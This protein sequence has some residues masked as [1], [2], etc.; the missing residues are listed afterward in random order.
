[1]EVMMKV[2]NNSNG[3]GSRVKYEEE[4]LI[5]R[6]GA[7]NY[8]TSINNAITMHQSPQ[9]LSTHHT[10]N[11]RVQSPMQSVKMLTA[12][13]DQFGASLIP[14]PKSP[15]LAIMHSKSKSP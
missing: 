11:Q 10:S 15:S 13:K 1:M 7:N 12:N 14:K 4:N 3:R 5:V 9:D 2:A 6:N 8:Q